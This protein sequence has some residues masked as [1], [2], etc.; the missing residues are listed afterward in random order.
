M[1]KLTYDKKTG[2]MFCI[3]DIVWTFSTNPNLVFH[4]ELVDMQG[5][6][7]VV[8]EKLYNLRPGQTK[9]D[10]EPTIIRHTVDSSRTYATYKEAIA[11]I[12]KATND[13]TL[14]DSSRHSS[15]PN[16]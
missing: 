11:G 7:V 16:L 15:L 9:D 2:S 12:R 1:T 5:S 6:K 3:G 8:A 13:N 14:Y 4:G 10:V